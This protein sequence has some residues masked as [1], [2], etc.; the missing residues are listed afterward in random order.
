MPSEDVLIRADYKGAF[1]SDELASLA[2]ALRETIPDPAISIGAYHLHYYRMHR[3]EVAHLLVRFR[4]ARPKP[5]AYISNQCLDAI[6]SW[7]REVWMRHQQIREEPLPIVLGVVYYDRSDQD[8][9]RSETLTRVILDRPTGEP[10]P[11]D[12]P[13]GR[14]GPGARPEPPT[15]LYGPHKDQN[16]PAR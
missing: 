14:G 13:V 2:G 3:H 6:L 4:F 12:G 10:K 11:C 1:A 15:W 5:P 7:A 16:Q 8:A 9:W